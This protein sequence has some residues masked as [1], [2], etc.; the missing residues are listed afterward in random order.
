MQH[1]LVL[2]LLSRSSN[3]RNHADIPATI[4]AAAFAEPRVR[5]VNL[6]LPWD[7]TMV[8]GHLQFPTSKTAT[9]H[10][11]L[12]RACPLSQLRRPFHRLSHLVILQLRRPRTALTRC[13]GT[14]CPGPS[15]YG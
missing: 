4:A 13:P 9:L 12:H 3:S 5:L 11:T 10:Q 1:S 15:H 8:K 7:L 2:A 6:R 14:T